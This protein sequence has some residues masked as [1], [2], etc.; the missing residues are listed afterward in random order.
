MSPVILLTATS[1]A[2]DVIQKRGSRLVIHRRDGLQPGE[3]LRC[4]KAVIQVLQPHYEDEPIP[5]GSELK[6]HYP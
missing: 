4:L 5:I 3:V 6:S 2:E 1:Y